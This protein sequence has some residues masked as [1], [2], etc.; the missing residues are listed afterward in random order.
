LLLELSGHEV[1]VASSGAAGLEA[2]ATFRPE[3]ILCD[4]GLPGRM[5]GYAVASALRDDPA[6]S[7]AIRIAMTGFGQDQDQR[8]AMEAGFERHLTKPVD[9]ELLE[10]IVRHASRESSTDAPR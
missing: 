1:A 10:R 2:A 4:I 7:S 6:L 3:V 9:P 5:D 8:R